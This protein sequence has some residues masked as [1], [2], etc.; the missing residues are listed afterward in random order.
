MVVISQVNVYY[1]EQHMHTL[2]I[3]A[4]NRNVFRHYILVFWWKSY[5]LYTQSVE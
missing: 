2:A 4:E 3:D 5:N 1:R